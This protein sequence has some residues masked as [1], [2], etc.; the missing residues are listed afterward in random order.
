MSPR[1]LIVDDEPS[2]V[3]GLQYAFERERFDVTVALDGAEAVSV[4][5]SEAFDLIVLDVMLPRLSGT[6]AC[7]RIR[8]TSAVP[9][10]ML[11]ARDAERDLLEGLEVGADDYMTKPFSAAELI[12]RARALLRRREL[13]RPLDQ[14][15]RTVGPIAIDLVH[16]TIEVDGRKVVLTPSEFKVLALLA[17]DPG[18]V[19]T[20]RQIMERLWDST[21]TGD[22]HTC[23]VHV[24][25]LRRKI[26]S[27]PSDP[28]HLLTVR[29]RG[30]MLTDKTVPLRQLLPRPR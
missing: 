20:R 15:V 23:E 17:S 27:D 26:E 10:I 25:S 14:M 11:T 8:A 18:V 3:R 30:Y 16:D 6:E 22:E 7:K 12:G 4:A 29:G 1:V 13:D 9:I 24:S 19:F 28:R 21:H 5:L 2:L